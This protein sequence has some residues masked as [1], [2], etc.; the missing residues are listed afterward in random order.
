MCPNKH[1]HPREYDHL[2]K[3]WTQQTTPKNKNYVGFTSFPL[4]AFSAVNY[5]RACAEYHGSCITM[6]TQH[7][8]AHL[9]ATPKFKGASQIPEES[10]V[11]KANV[12][13]VYH[14]ENRRIFSLKSLR[15]LLMIDL[16]LTSP[17]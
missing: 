7:S 17:A 2:K 4:I 5:T 1:C 11:F 14:K 10:K 3:E 8:A 15:M 6:G 16:L 13:F 12:V 9:H